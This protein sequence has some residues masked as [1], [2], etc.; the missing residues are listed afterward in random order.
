MAAS[1]D[2]AAGSAGWA[3]DRPA[4]S[5]TLG[6]AVVA[7]AAVPAAAA[8]PGWGFL[9]AA[10]AVEQ[11]LLAVAWAGLLGATR[12][13]AL[14]VIAGAVAAD[15]VV[16]IRDTDTQGHLGDLVGVVGIAVA[17]VVA[18]PRG[19]PGRGAGSPA[20]A[21][22]RG[23]G[24]AGVLQA[25]DRPLR[26]GPLGRDGIW[27]G[28]G[29]DAG[30]RLVVAALVGAG[31]AVLVGRLVAAIPPAVSTRRNWW[32]PMA[33]IVGAAAG[34]GAAAAYGAPA[35]RI[36][37]SHALAV[38]AAAAWAGG[39]VALAPPQGR[40]GGGRPPRAGGPLVAVLPLAAAA[41]V[42]FGVSH[43]LAG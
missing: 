17:V 37:V 40:G 1:V 6:L 15:L 36:S 10:L 5:W 32:P 3:G 12:P 14:T 31:A 16:A 8:L 22:A 43:L 2:S 30:S 29:P 25:R 34:A 35:T 24:T 41:P 11:V 18:G 42:A 13:A 33:R 20:N 4:P 9:L 27:Y 19:R 21:P 38:G 28:S 7:A 39:R 26:A 23:G